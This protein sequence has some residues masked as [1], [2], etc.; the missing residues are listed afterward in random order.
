MVRIPEKH[1][2][3]RAKNLQKKKGAK[4]KTP[5]K[6]KKKKRARQKKKRRAKE[7]AKNIYHAQIEPSFFFFEK[8]GAS[9]IGNLLFSNICF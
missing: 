1:A 8:E 6:L 4:K 5:S 3:G 7:G 2:F 9:K